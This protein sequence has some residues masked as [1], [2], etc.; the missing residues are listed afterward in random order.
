VQ[1]EAEQKILRVFFG[2]K[3]RL[4]TKQ[5]SWD[6]GTRLDIDHESKVFLVLLGPLLDNCRLLT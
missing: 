6:K 5:K 1:I 3:F 2:G 4:S